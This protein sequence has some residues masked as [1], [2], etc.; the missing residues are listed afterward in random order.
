MHNHQSPAAL[1]ASTGQ[2]GECRPG[3]SARRSR[4]DQRDADHRAGHRPRAEIQPRAPHAP[5]GRGD[6]LP[7]AGGQPLR[8][9]AQAAGPERLQLARQRQDQP[10]PQRRNRRTVAIAVHFPRT[11]AHPEQPGGQLEPHRSRCRLLQHPAAGRPRT[12][13]RRE[14]PQG[15]ARA[16]A[17]RAHRLLA[18]RQRPETACRGAEHPRPGRTG[19]GRLAHGGNRAPAQP[20]RC[21]AL[22]T[23]GTG[24]PAPARGDRPGTVDRPD[25]TGRPDQR[26]HRPA[27][28][29]RRAG[30]QGQPPDPGHPGRT[31]G[32]NGDGRQRRHPR[33]ALQ[34]PDCAG[35]NPQDLG[36]PVPQSQLQLQH[37]LR[38][39]QV[40]GE[41]QLERGRPAAVLQPVQPVHRSRPTEAG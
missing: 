9:A 31:L 18:C 25:R 14:A 22:P 38:H 41:Q 11:H 39:R 3:R 7:P 6:G 27:T 4:A 21:P 35:G 26:S 5:D 34:R 17:G 40:S 19:P 15:H 1:R 30:V 37:Q 13:R 20:S 10:E 32:R 28:A 24:K 12:D 29:A 8:H 16:D 2:T 36:P 33:A 23:S